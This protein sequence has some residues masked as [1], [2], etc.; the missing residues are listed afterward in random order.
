M[1]TE[2]WMLSQP[3]VFFSMDYRTS[4]PSPRCFSQASASPR[5]LL[6]LSHRYSP[7]AVLCAGL[8]PNIA[9]MHPDCLAA[10]LVRPQSTTAAAAAPPHAPPRWLTAGN[11]DVAI[12]PSSVNHSVRQFSSPFL[13]YHEKVRSHA[14]CPHTLQF[15]SLASW[16]L[17]ALHPVTCKLYSQF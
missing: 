1:R 6:L 13:V 7:Q 2:N 8:Y 5:L 9:S 15:S 10:S 11:V 12:H 4:I 3:C 16:E 14:V 17:F